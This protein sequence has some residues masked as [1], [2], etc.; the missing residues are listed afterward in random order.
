MK[1]TRIFHS[2]AT[3]PNTGEVVKSLRVETDTLKVYKVLNS[4]D[5]LKKHGSMDKVLNDLRVKEGQ[6][7]DYVV[8]PRHTDLGTIDA[9]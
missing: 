5:E 4:L 8:L 3:N 6:F 2:E 9:W 1:F 7:G